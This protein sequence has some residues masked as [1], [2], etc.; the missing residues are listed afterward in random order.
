MHPRKR[1]RKNASAMKLVGELVGVFRVAAGPT[2][3]QLAERVGHQVETIASIEQGRRALLPD[4][5]H[6]LDELLETKGHWRRPWETCRR[7]T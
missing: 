6:R 2:Q 7:W 5:A 1:Q 4:L 3:A